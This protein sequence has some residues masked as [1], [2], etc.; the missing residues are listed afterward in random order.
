MTIHAAVVSAVIVAAAWPGSSPAASQTAPA[1]RDPLQ[2]PR[3]VFLQSPGPGGSGGG[4]GNRQP[5]PPSRARAIGRDRVTMPV[6]KRVVASERPTDV[7][8]PPPEIVLDA[9]SL[10]SGMSLL[11]GLPEAPASLPFSQGPGSGGGVGEGTGTGIGSGTGPGLGPGSGGG[12]G[13]GAYRPGNGVVPPTVLREVKPTYTADAMRQRIQGTVVLE[14][15]VGRDGTPLAIR[16]TRA[17]DPGLDQEAITAVQGWRFT[18]GRIGTTPVDVLV[19]VVLD[20][21]IR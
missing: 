2:L 14:V 6:A 8:P 19:T 13:G 1:T 10:A 3:I 15:V 5:S 12:F 21:S 18:P 16:V 17:L 4:G 7:T 11:T 20:F 9:R